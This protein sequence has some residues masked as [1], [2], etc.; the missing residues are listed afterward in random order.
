MA[1][2]MSWVSFIHRKTAAAKLFQ[3][4]IQSIIG[5]MFFYDRSNDN[6]MVI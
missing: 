6:V 1:L 3:I 5:T 4:I 2:V